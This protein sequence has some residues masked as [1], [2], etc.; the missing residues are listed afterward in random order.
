MISAANEKQEARFYGGHILAADALQSDGRN[1]FDAGAVPENVVAGFAGG[2]NSGGCFAAC[3]R[4]Y[5]VS[6]GSAG[7]TGG[8]D[9]QCAFA[10]DLADRRD[11]ERTAGNGLPCVLQHPSKFC[12]LS[13]GRGSENFWEKR[14]TGK[15]QLHFVEKA[16]IIKERSVGQQKMECKKRTIGFGRD[17]LWQKQQHCTWKAL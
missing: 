8:L 3:I 1:P 12:V 16:C 17:F 7:G 11:G 15:K 6:A 4:K 2:C 9:G 5:S 10:A 14:R 13:C